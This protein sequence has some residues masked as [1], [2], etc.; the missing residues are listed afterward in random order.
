M[1]RKA[2]RYYINNNRYKRSSYISWCY[3]KLPQYQGVL[4]NPVTGTGTT[5]TLPKFT[6]TS[7]IGDSNITDNGSLINLNSSTRINSGQDGLRIGADSN[8]VINSAN[9]SKRGRLNVP[10]YG[11]PASLPIAIL[12]GAT[13]AASN[14]IQIG[15]TQGGYA[16]AAD[17]IS[18]FIGAT[19]NATTATE[20]ARFASNGALGIGTTSLTGY[21]LRVS[22]N[23]T[24]SVSSTGIQSGGAIQSDVTSDAQYFSSAASTAAASF[25]ITDLAHYVANQG[26]FGVGSTVTKQYGYR[27]AASLIG[28]TN[29]YAFFSDIPIGT[30]RWNLYMNGTAANYLAGVL[31][32]GTTTLS[33]FTLDVNG[34]ARV[35]GQLTANSFVPTSSTIPTNGMYLSA[36]A[37]F[38]FPDE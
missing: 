29:N 27:V 25:T 14:S 21:S 28:A 37:R 22:K 32:I 20:I 38:E 13:D 33:G 34:T 35:S 2:K 8:G 10:Q 24:G 11:N 26:T 7:A 5:N 18:F 6:G 19:Y 31:N 15:G 17:V 23:I 30:N 3:F 36:A 1:E 12:Q 16:L 4:T 9:T